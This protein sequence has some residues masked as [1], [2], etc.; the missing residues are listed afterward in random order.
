MVTEKKRGAAA[1]PPIDA[2]VETVEKKK[3]QV[4]FVVEHSY[5]GNKVVYSK[6]LTEN[7]NKDKGSEKWIVI[8]LHK[9]TVKYS[10]GAVL[11]FEFGEHE[12]KLTVKNADLLAAT[13]IVS[14]LF[15]Y[16]TNPDVMEADNAKEYSLAYLAK[17]FV[18][19]THKG[20]GKEAVKSFLISQDIY[21][22][23]TVLEDRKV[24][25]RTL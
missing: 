15:D 10:L 17:E 2:T 25:V 14:P 19:H 4:G 8:L 3:F 16:I 13:S 6:V 9:P 1:P 12:G 24:I 22:I 11:S 23:I 20:M 7:P 5:I 18:K 21:T